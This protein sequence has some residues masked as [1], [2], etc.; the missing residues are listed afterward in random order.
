MIY[1]FSFSHF[2]T[3]KSDL[4]IKFDIRW[5]DKAPAMLSVDFIKNFEYSWRDIDRVFKVRSKFIRCSFKDFYTWKRW[6][7]NN[8]DI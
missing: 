3:R 5:Q 8:Y 7:K 6:E 4:T 1:Y 2:S